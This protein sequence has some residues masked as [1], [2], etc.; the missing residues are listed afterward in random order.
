MFITFLFIF[1][2]QAATTTMVFGEESVSHYVDK[3]RAGDWETRNAAESAIL[4]TRKNTIDALLC[5]LQERGIAGRDTDSVRRAIYILGEMRAT[6]ASEDLVDAIVFPVVIAG[7][8]RPKLVPQR[9]GSA[10]LETKGEEKYPAVEA[11]VKIGEPCLPFVLR[12]IVNTKNDFELRACLRVLTELKG[13]AKAVETLE[14][15]LCSTDLPQSRESIQNAIRV[16]RK[17][18]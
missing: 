18:E 4:T 1:M 17:T 3:L 12:K 6:N 16:L 9:M 11:L 10:L 7:N 8:G 13:N 2:L 5:L 14:A 15:E